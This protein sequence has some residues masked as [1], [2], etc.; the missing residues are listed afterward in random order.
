MNLTQLFH[1]INVPYREALEHRS[2]VISLIHPHATEMDLS[3][4][5]ALYF[6]ARGV[7]HVRND[8][9][10]INT[11]ATPARVLLSGL[12]ADELFGGYTRHANAFSRRGFPGLLEE[13]E[14]DFSRLSKRNLGRDDRVISHWAK[15]VRYPFLDESVVRWALRS[16]IWEKCGFGQEWTTLDKHMEP[17]KMVLRLLARKLGL[18]GAAAEMKRAV[19][20]VYN[21]LYQKY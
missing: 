18:E 17:G 8:N 2:Q 19:S 20:W 9:G 21:C 16:P 6:A 10:G 12:G 4:G 7:G 13:L 3:I 1:Q 11:Y 5:Y 15:E 14:L